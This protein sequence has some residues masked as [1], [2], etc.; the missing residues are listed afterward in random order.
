L[1]HDKNSLIGP[2]ISGKANIMHEKV[3]SKKN[4]ADLT[5][6]FEVKDYFNLHDIS[7][8]I[9]GNKITAITGFSGAGKTSL[10]LDSLVPAIDSKKNKQALPK[11]VTKLDTKLTNVV[12]IDAKPV[13][14][15]TRSS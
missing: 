14:K 9:P 10:I 8:S 5:T 6:N 15:N 1:V 12:S 3:P 13:G 7:A 2:F 11:Q 4:A